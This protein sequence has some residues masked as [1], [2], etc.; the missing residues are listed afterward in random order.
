M[1][2]PQSDVDSSRHSAIPTTGRP[3]Q[4]NYPAHTHYRSSSFANNHRSIAISRQVA[5]G[6]SWRHA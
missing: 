4:L 6:A 5:I 2:L 3:V 1:S